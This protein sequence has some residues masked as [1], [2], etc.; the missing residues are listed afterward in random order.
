MQNRPTWPRVGR[1]QPSVPRAPSRRQRAGRP[2]RRSVRSWH[3]T[4]AL[5]SACAGP[6]VLYALWRQV[7]RRQRAAWGGRGEG[8]AL[9]SCREERERLYLSCSLAEAWPPAAAAGQVVATASPSSGAVGCAAVRRE[10]EGESRGGEAGEQ[11]E[12]KSRPDARLLVDAVN[13]VQ[14]GGKG[15][16]D[17]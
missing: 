9:C 8:A 11:R 7:A 10:K 2:A 5:P 4:S 14:S 17:I 1:E 3:W 12:G 6:Q 13:E 15:E 16:R